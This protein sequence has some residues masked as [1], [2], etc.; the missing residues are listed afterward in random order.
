MSAGPGPARYPTLAS[1]GDPKAIVT[2][3]GLPRISTMIMSGKPNRPFP[4]EYGV[5]I[6]EM[7]EGGKQ[8]IQFVT[9]RVQTG[10]WENLEGLL[11][12]NCIR[13]LR[14][15][16][17][18]V[19]PEERDSIGVHP[20]D[21]FFSFIPQFDFQK[22]K[23]SILLVT[24]SMPRL[25]ELRDMIK[26]NKDATKS[27]MDKIQSDVKEGVISKE[28]AKTDIRKRMKE[29]METLKEKG[30]STTI[31]K[32]NDILIGNYRFERENS[33]HEWTIVE[34]SQVDSRK[35]WHW[36]FQKRWKGRLGISLRGY[37]FYNVLRYDY[38]TDLIAYCIVFNIMTGSMLTG[39]MISAPHS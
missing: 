33:N 13:G 19:T 30:D 3:L 18:S 5:N 36:I 11:S 6:D 8:A 25:A 15:D 21:I 23:Q 26:E 32:A 1:R 14:K 37:D 24:F 27:L 28:E 20:D 2:S 4:A 38:I 17:E 31:F 35:A 7:T 9:Q 29:T 12:D 34:L 10:E 22:N 16:L 39:G